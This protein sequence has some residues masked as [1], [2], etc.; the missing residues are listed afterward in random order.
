M[1]TAPSGYL[2]CALCNRFELAT[3]KPICNRC[4]DNLKHSCPVV[5]MNCRK[6]DKAAVDKHILW[7]PRDMMDAPTNAAINGLES[8]TN[9]PTVFAQ[10]ACNNCKG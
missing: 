5:C 1:T 3:G 4:E 9:G 10:L 8:V 7:V 6:G 2:R